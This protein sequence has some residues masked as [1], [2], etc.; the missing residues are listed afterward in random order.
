MV[1]HLKLCWKKSVK[2]SDSTFFMDN[3]NDKFNHLHTIVASPSKYL[4]W[5]LNLYKSCLSFSRN[6]SKYLS[7]SLM[8]FLGRWSS[9]LWW[10]LPSIKS[11]TKT[12][13]L[14]P[15]HCLERK[16]I[17]YSGKELEDSVDNTVWYMTSPHQFGILHVCV[18]FIFLHVVLL[19]DLQTFLCMGSFGCRLTLLL[20]WILWMSR[21][22]RTF[23]NK[24]VG[25][26]PWSSSNWRL[27]FFLGLNRNP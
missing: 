12:D 11:N 23:I 2:L 17:G 6:W 14:R 5:S 24:V 3:F 25:N 9:N 26:L 22:E 16:L 20:Y 4:I 27:G 21:E 19:S 8:K 1:G 18:I 10:R 15:S 7:Q 13:D